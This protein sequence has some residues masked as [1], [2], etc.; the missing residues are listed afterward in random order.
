MAARWDEVEQAAAQNRHEL[1][2]TGPEIASRVEKSGLDNAVFD[3]KDLNFLEI[4]KAHLTA[5]P[6]TLSNLSNLTNLVIHNNFLTTLPLS[7][8]GLKKLKLLDVSFNKLESLPEEI[9]Q[10]SELYR[11]NANG[12]NLTSFPDVSSLTQ[13]HEL[14]ISHNQL[15]SL[16][17]GITSKQ[18]LLLNSILASSNQIS[19]LPSDLPN[20]PVLRVLDVSDNK[21]TEIPAEISECA[22]LRDFKFS[23]NKYKDRRMQKMMVSSSTK[24]VLDYLGTVLEKERQSQG[25]GKG[26]GKKGKKGKGKAVQESEIDDLMTDIINVL[27]FPNDDAATGVTIQLKEGVQDVRPAIV[28]AIVRDLHMTET[29]NMFKRFIALQVFQIISFISMFF[30]NEK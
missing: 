20:L 25:G 30:I 5:V 23:G 14:D 6:D 9:T 17:P 16:P 24:S 19:E 11:F 2:L 7:I 13:L 29:T 27:H 3:L 15:E 12:N 10:L 18:L 21:L 26:K 4:S 22:K 1:V 28:C 8:G